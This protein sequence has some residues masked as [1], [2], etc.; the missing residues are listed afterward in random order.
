[1][2][3]F[4]T[5]TS[6]YAQK[7]KS[8]I[9]RET[10]SSQLLAGLFFCLAAVLGN[11]LGAHYGK[12]YSSDYFTE[13]NFFFASTF[14]WIALIVIGPFWAI[15]SAFFGSLYIVYLWDGIFAPLII[16]PAEIMFGAFV[17]RA[18]S[19]SRINSA[20]F[21]FWTVAC[22]P[23]TLLFAEVADI[24]LKSA[25]L[26]MLKQALN[27]Q[28]NA[29]IAACIITFSKPIRSSSAFLRKHASASS[30]YSAMM[31]A[32][33]GLSFFLP[34]CI[35][36]LGDLGAS[37]QKRMDKELTVMRAEAFVTASNA[38]TAIRLETIFWAGQVRRYLRTQELNLDKLSDGLTNY[39]DSPTQIF[40][41]QT[42]GEW[43]SV[44]G[45]IP[46]KNSFL[47]E[48]DGQ[49]WQHNFSKNS[50]STI[51]W[52]CFQNQYIS[53]HIP[54]NNG[55][56]LVFA[57]SP[58]SVRSA[59][60]ILDDVYR[61]T[62]KCVAGVNEDLALAEDFTVSSISLNRSN[63]VTSLQTWS[64]AHVEAM[65][66]L[67]HAINP[68][69]VK[70][71]HSAAGMYASIQDEGLRT[72]LRMIFYAGIVVTIGVLLDFLFRRWIANFS[73]MS[74]TYFNDPNSLPKFLDTDF[75]EDQEIKKWWEKFTGAIETQSE[76]RL[77]A[78]NNLKK[79]IDQSSNPI[80]GTN[81][82]G[83]ITAWNKALADL[84]GFPE[85]EMLGTALSMIT[86]NSQQT[87]LISNQNIENLFVD[88]RTKNGKRIPLAISQILIDTELDTP[89]S[90]PVEKMESVPTA[91]YHIALNL[92]ALKE[93]ESKLIHASRL[94]ALGEM[95]S[96]FA[97]E[98][99]QPLNII[100][101]STGNALERAKEQSVPKEYF[102]SKLQRVE[103]QALRAG[104]II[105]GIRQF[106]LESGEDEVTTFDPV[107]QTHV[108]IAL[109]REQLHIATISIE[110]ST[111]AKPVYISGRSILFEQ[112]I[113][114]LLTNARQAML[115]Q[116]PSSR[117]IDID[118]AVKRGFVIITIKDTGPGIPPKDLDQVFKQFFSTKKNENGS[119]IGLYAS[120]T[121]VD[122]MGG[123][124]E[125]VKST[126]G[127][128]IQ[129]RLPIV[130]NH[131]P[132]KIPEVND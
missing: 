8:L 121:V 102:I 6:P 114:N 36:E 129:I 14:S 64:T 22:V 40:A 12:I 46:L 72:F 10:A 49:I 4:L 79:F 11:V 44:Y 98:L 97:H 70:I 82:N 21:L 5:E 91:R 116:E 7:L 39:P 68:A 18:V 66:K 34:I 113:V 132:L 117:K 77:L 120:K 56:A 45:S 38:E 83:E 26:G 16:F 105:Q 92:S 73:R 62:T 86:V 81:N 107:A 61:S 1:M 108:A 119:G 106:V 85:E 95:A 27:G 84:S 54:A 94:A 19:F 69:T 100:S 124:I 128:C 87:S 37:F 109:I 71:S 41:H 29:L 131:D 48:L 74:E 59:S 24:P 58:E 63:A 122:T 3:T 130:V 9:I 89:N 60:A 32:L 126:H 42:N 47:Q 101:L 123:Q 110:V 53:L 35:Y 104:K 25:L 28:I 93:A 103:E 111:L 31:Q 57:W 99:N 13:V 90:N 23:V 43:V 78:Q 15:L 30:S 20:V 127:A 65:S 76:R 75:A 118:F 96:S 67:R 115:Q 50:P 88:L 17:W 112:T 125:A 55:S 2:D 33:F 80:F 51:F 52:G